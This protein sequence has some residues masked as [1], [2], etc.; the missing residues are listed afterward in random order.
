MT[1]GPAPVWTRLTPPDPATAATSAHFASFLPDHVLELF[2]AEQI[3]CSL[4]V[5]TDVWFGNA[6]DKCLGAAPDQ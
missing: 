4:R 1:A 6:I 2:P 3:E 5:F